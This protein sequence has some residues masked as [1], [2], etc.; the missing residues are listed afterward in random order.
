MALIAAGDAGSVLDAIVGTIGSPE[1]HAMQKDARAKALLAFA[2]STEYL[3]LR[4][5]LGMGVA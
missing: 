3:E 5:K 2:L 4:S 1:R